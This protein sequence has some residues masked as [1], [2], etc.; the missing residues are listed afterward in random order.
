MA[1][2]ASIS[3]SRR[4]AT[5]NAAAS[6]KMQARDFPWWLAAIGLIAV[7]T[8]WQIAAKPNYSE[9]FDFIRAGLGVTVSTSLSAYMVALALGLLAGLWRLSNNRVAGNL[10]TLYIELVRGVP[11]LVLIFFIALVLVPA[12]VGGLQAA[13]AQIAALGLTGP[14]DWLSGLDARSIPMNVRAVVALSITYG[15]FQAEIIR[16]G[17]QSVGKGQ[18]EAARALGMTQRQAMVYVVLPQ[19]VRNILP[20]LGNEFISMLKDSSLVSVLAVRDITQVARLYAG[21]SFRF[22]E[23]YTV[24]AVLYLSM[25]LFLSGLVKLLERRYG[26]GAKR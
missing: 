26:S 20:A 17:I 21:Q 24:L 4:A 7:V 10:A 13:V 14:A 1:A 6:T 5:Q 15:A 3:P 16:A 19:A 18:M 8:A 2:R 22:S 12:A 23:A 11:M 25:T 9:A